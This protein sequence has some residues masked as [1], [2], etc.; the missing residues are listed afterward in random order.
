MKS[1]CAPRPSSARQPA[2]PP[3]QLLVSDVRV[4]DGG[5]RAR[6]AR[7]PLGEEQVAGGA[8]AAADPL[9]AQPQLPV[10][11][12]LDGET[13]K[14]RARVLALLGRAMAGDWRSNSM[15]ML[16]D[17]RL[18]QPFVKRGPWDPNLGP[19]AYV[20]ALPLSTPASAPSGTALRRRCGCTR[21]WS[22]DLR[23]WQT[24]VP[25]TGLSMPGRRW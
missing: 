10:V 5:Q 4:H 16:L 23:A 18:H 24:S 1:A 11:R 22:T 19:S 13:G 12:Q 21:W 7:E 9:Q 17:R 8:A 6:M 20:G 14:S 25:G 15:L 2:H 3:E